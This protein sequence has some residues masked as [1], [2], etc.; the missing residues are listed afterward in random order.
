LMLALFRVIE[1]SRGQI[2][3]NGTDIAQI[4][5]QTLRSNISIIPQ[6]PTIFTGDLRFQV[7][8]FLQFS[9]EEVWAVL[10]HVNLDA[11]VKQQM[12]AGLQS[13]IKEN[14]ENLSQGQRQLLCIARALLRKTPL[15]VVDEGTSAVDPHTDEIIQQVLRLEAEKN[16][17]T[18]FAIAHRIQTIADFDRILVLGDG[19]IVEFDAPA[20]L[21]QQPDSA[22]RLMAVQAEH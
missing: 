4:P 2:F 8:P 12:E 10:K 19:K 13:C 3:L 6:D 17:T 5:L 9:D 15:L 21:M 7:D 1:L 16:G 11:F 20:V 22:F 18:I 14:G